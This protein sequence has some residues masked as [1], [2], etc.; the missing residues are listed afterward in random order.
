MNELRYL[1]THR[2]LRNLLDPL[3][4]QAPP[5][6]L[7]APQGFADYTAESYVAYVRTLYVE[8][9]KPAPLADFAVRINAKGN[10]VITVRR[11][12]KYLTSAEVQELATEVGYTLQDMWMCLNKRKVEIRVPKKEQPHAKR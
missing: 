6:K 8:P 12:P 3:L 1:R 11:K 10:P 7:L 4:R 5:M 9:P 2:I